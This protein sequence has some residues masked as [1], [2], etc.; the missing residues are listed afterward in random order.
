MLEWHGWEVDRAVNAFMLG[1]ITPPR[2]YLDGIANPSASASST[3]GAAAVAGGGRSAGSYAEALS[4]NPLTHA[5]GVSQGFD[6]LGGGGVADGG[7]AGRRGGRGER[8]P[9]GVLSVVFG[10]PFRLVG[11]VR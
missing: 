8:G 4:G 1:D 11:K 2:S 7:A 9:P 6:V 5:E 10:L 3:G